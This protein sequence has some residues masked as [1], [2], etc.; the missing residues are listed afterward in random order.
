M[1]FLKRSCSCFEISGSYKIAGRLP[2]QSKTIIKNG[3]VYADG[4]ATPLV[5]TELSTS[6]AR[7][8]TVPALPLSFFFRVVA[9]DFETGRS[10]SARQIQ[11]TVPGRRPCGDF[12]ILGETCSRHAR[13][14]QR[15][16]T[17]PRMFGSPDLGQRSANVPGICA[18]RWTFVQGLAREHDTSSRRPK[19]TCI[20]FPPPPFRHNCTAYTGRTPVCEG[21]VLSQILTPHPLTVFGKV[22]QARDHR[23]KDGRHLPFHLRVC[24]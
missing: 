9:C 16:Q 11:V 23:C 17:R 10:I 1:I 12:K 14:S 6:P 8:C 19:S 20:S 2:G 7:L 18:P 24:K 13:H 15:A 22:I 4:H 21:A 5:C 3:T